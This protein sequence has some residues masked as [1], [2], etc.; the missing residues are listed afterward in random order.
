VGYD[1][2]MTIVAITGHRPE[3]IEDP[4]D[5]KVFL[6]REFERLAPDRVIQGCASGVDLWAGEM[7]IHMGFDVTS[8]KPWKG[9]KP[10]KADRE[11][12]EFVINNSKEVVD[13]T[14]YIAYPGPW[15]Y[16][17][18]NKW[19]VD[20]AN[21]VLA[22]WDG[23]AGGTKN[24]GDYAMKKNIPIIRYHPVCKWTKESNA[25]FI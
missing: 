4:I 25:R 2:R 20:N 1:D 10:R 8:A 15:V 7:A 3:K 14:E 19:M 17:E 22:V 9:F 5:V 12:Y 13:V 6:R 24:C 18:R 23:T 21:L 16:Q 11:L